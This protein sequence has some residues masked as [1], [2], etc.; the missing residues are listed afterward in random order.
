MLAV[1]ELGVMPVRA[2][3]R[4]SLPVQLF[5][6]RS[7]VMTVVVELSER[8]PEVPSIVVLG[9]SRRLVE[10]LVVGLARHLIRVADSLPA[11]VVLC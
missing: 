5:A 9:K 10:Q 2:D 1:V 3:I 8:S 6:G 4:W 11:D 7:A